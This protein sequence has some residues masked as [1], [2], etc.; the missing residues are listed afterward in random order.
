[1]AEL[2]GRVVL[3]T[4]ATGY[5]GRAIAL[6]VA[7][8]GG[9]PVVAGRSNERLAA[10][11]ND[12]GHDGHVSHA[13]AFDVSE[14]EQC[15][16]AIGE[17][18]DR[19]G[20]LDGVVNCANQ[21]RVG[22]I[23]TSGAADFEASWRQNLTGPF[24][25]V[26]AA[27]P[28]LRV[29]GARLRGGASIVNISSMYGHVSPDPRIYGESGA[30]NPPFYG[31][32]KAGLM[33]LTRYLAVHLGPDRIRVNSVSPGPFPAPAIA[34]TNPV[35]HARLCEKTALGRIGVADEVAGPVLFL[36]SDAASFVTGTDLLVDGGWTAW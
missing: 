22:T 33:Q 25:L 18:A 10:L 26:K 13:V 19:V 23:E 11:T 17:I 34:Q 14:P 28:L 24:T 6:A 16:R 29:A 1:V 35:F 21:S 9:I 36:L 5:L 20:R 4:G 12:I 31:A 27:L 15:T 30:N 7:E 2:A 3:V 32:A 8:A